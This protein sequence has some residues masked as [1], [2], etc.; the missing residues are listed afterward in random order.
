MQNLNYVSST[1][2]TEIQEIEKMYSNQAVLTYVLMVVA[3]FTFSLL[4]V[5]AP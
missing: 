2:C 3:T 1:P 5:L 4:I